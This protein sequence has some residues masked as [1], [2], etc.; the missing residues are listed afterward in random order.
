MAS[1][2]I[3]RIDVKEI[4]LKKAKKV[5]LKPSELPYPKV[6]CTYINLVFVNLRIYCVYIIYLCGHYDLASGLPEVYIGKTRMTVYER[7][8]RY[9]SS[10]RNKS[11][12]QNLYRNR[13]YKVIY[14]CLTNDEAKLMEIRVIKEVRES[15]TWFPL[16]DRKGGETGSSDGRYT[17][18]IAVIDLYIRKIR[19][20]ITLYKLFGPDFNTT[21]MLLPHEVA[22]VSI[23]EI[24]KNPQDFKDIRYC[25]D[26]VAQEWENISIKNASGRSK[27]DPRCEISNIMEFLQHIP[28]QGYLGK[29]GFVEHPCFP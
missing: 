2:E 13:R 22:D 29:D 27:E 10:T 20:D 6:D 23:K 1:S 5:G 24:L 14:G 21:R 3:E 16:N 8:S 28:R 25:I 26:E 4:F 9:I 11:K 18:L 7:V 12:Y 19:N 17:F 15:K